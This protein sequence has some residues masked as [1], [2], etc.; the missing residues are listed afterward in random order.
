MLE[1]VDEKG[2]VE[3]PTVEDRRGLVVEEEAQQLEV[4]R[5]YLKW[6]LSL[7]GMLQPFNF[8]AR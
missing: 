2:N 5:G 6:R 8:T 1:Q 3:K 4:G 7:K